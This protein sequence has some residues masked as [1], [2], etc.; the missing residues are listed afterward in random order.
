[1]KVIEATVYVTAAGS[2]PPACSVIFALISDACTLDTLE[3]LVI[4]TSCCLTLPVEHPL[5]ECLVS[6]VYLCLE[7]L[8]L[9]QMCGLYLM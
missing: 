6:L 3:I 4:V 8:L 7:Q 1:M 5:F 2:A 9:H